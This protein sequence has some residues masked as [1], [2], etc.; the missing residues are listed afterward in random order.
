MTLSSGEVV[1][2]PNQSRMGPTMGGTGAKGWR[3]VSKRPQDS[4]RDATPA[5]RPG[6]GPAPAPAKGN[7]F[8]ALSDISEKSPQVHRTLLCLRSSDWF[9]VI[10]CWH[11]R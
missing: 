1:L 4:R 11:W 5:S 10:K 7:I 9:G 8:A 6:S 2:G 3:D